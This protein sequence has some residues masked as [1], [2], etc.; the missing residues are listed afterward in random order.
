MNGS[1]SKKPS[2][3]A[4]NGLTLRVMIAIAGIAMP[5]TWL[6]KR[7]IVDAIHN[8]TKSPW[9]HRLPRETFVGAGSCVLGGG[10]SDT[11]GISGGISEG[12]TRARLPSEGD[13][14]TRRTELPSEGKTPSLGSALVY[15]LTHVSQS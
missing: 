5:L 2:R 7:L 13:A 4:S 3:A 9:R 8:F 14:L 11:G 12:D 6:P 1:I 10:D 15:C